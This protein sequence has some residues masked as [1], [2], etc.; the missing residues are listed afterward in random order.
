MSA[1]KNNRQIEGKAAP[2]AQR[3]MNRTILKGKTSAVSFPVKA[4]AF[5]MTAVGVLAASSLC[6]APHSRHARH[7]KPQIVSKPLF[8]SPPADRAQVVNDVRARHSEHNGSTAHFF[9]FSA[10]LLAYGT[11][12]SPS[13][14]FNQEEWGVD[15][16]G[17]SYHV[18][19]SMMDVMGGPE[20]TLRASDMKALKAAIHAL[21]AGMLVADPEREHLLI[22]SVRDGKQWLTRNYDA[23]KLPQEVLALYK[24]AG[25]R[26]PLVAGKV[27]VLQGTP[28]GPK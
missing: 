18:Y 23:E 6:A 25:V 9:R 13:D 21:P 2:T 8:T 15:V 4:T 3:G 26:L 27:T 19:E 10:P 28:A 5:L 1:A 20:Q 22:L 12:F 7:A 14:A 16:K 11:V 24:I 17:R